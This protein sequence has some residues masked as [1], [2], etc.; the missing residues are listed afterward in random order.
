M[1]EVKNIIGY[2]NHQDIAA[3]QNSLQSTLSALPSWIGV[4]SEVSPI[5]SGVASFGGFINSV[6]SAR[7]TAAFQQDLL[8]SLQSIQSTLNGIATDLSGI[9]ATIQELATELQ[10]LALSD[11]ITSIENWGIYL[12]A[13]PTDM[14]VPAN[15]Q[16]AQNLAASMMDADNGATNL[17]GCMLGIHDAMVG[18]DLGSP[19]IAQLTPEAFFQLRGRL[20][21]GLHLLAFATAFNPGEPFDYG[22]FLLTWS[23]NFQAQTQFY[24]EYNLEPMVPMASENAA[25]GNNYNQTVSDGIVQYAYLQPNVPNVTLQVTLGDGAQ[26]PI[27]TADTLTV[28]PATATAP[29]QSVTATGQG[30]ARVDIYKNTI[31]IQNSCPLNNFGSESASLNED[32][33]LFYICGWYSLSSYYNQAYGW[34]TQV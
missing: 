6:V 4:L 12:A 17:Q 19:L 16:G 15:L 3:T 5:L 22:T 10:G 26:F 23:N 32:T 1:M 31:T 30:Y 28:A 7:E 27:S 25:D 20:V 9:E 29:M 33:P 21:Q 18:G 24:F 34:N 8:S 14:T 13:L 11:K 2:N